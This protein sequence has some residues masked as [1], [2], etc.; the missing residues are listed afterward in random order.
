MCP[1]I[2]LRKSKISKELK[3]SNVVMGNLNLLGWMILKYD[4]STRDY[5]N[6]LLAKLCAITQKYYWER[7]VNTDSHR[8]I[9]FPS[10]YNGD[11]LK[12]Q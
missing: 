3:I 6:E 12:N 5:L 1:F 11:R 9:L 7:L 8:R 4:I 2:D 10:I